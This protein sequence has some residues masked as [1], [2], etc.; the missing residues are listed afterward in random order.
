MTS[1]FETPIFSLS[2]FTVVIALSSFRRAINTNGGNTS[3]IITCWIEN[4]QGADM[5]LQSLPHMKSSHPSAFD[6]LKR[7]SVCLT[8]QRRKAKDW[9]FH[10]LT[11]TLSLTSSYLILSTAQHLKELL[12][13]FWWISEEEVDSSFFPVEIL[14]VK[15]LLARYLT[16]DRKFRVTDDK[17]I[18]SVVLLSSV[19]FKVPEC[20]VYCWCVWGSHY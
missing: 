17:D 19:C 9:H 8:T 16:Y 20:R 3:E 14:K 4:Q 7:R 15:N 12:S 18:L 2:S 5:W 1:E 11:R 13:P 10:N 6:A